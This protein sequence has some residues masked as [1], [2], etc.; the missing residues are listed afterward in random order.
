MTAHVA[1][2]LRP[3]AC[4]AI[5]LV[6]AVGVSA[7]VPLVAGAAAAAGTATVITDRRS[8]G[9][10]LDDG[11]I[12]LKVEGQIYR[13][14]SDLVRVSAHVYNGMVLLLGEVPDAQSSSRAEAIAR[15]S[16]NVKSVLNQITVGPPQT[17]SER[18]NDTWLT[19]K[20]KTAL[21]RAHYVPSNTIMVTTKR[22]TVYL[23][24]LASVNEGRNAASAAAGVGGVRKVIKLFETISQEEAIRLSGGEAG[25]S[26]G[27]GTPI[28][29]QKAAPIVDNT[30]DAG[31]Q[32]GGNAGGVEVMPIK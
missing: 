7:C 20:V 10:Q 17:L 16:L 12:G 13:E 11:N 23:M 27:K 6:V 26:D 1:G 2:L 21:V 22:G 24:G 15:G 28:A 25:R 8:S 29:E 32:L 9:A 14:M 18:T 30:N 31:G 4:I 3:A 19:S 5:V